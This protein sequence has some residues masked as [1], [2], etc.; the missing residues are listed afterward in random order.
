MQESGIPKF[1]MT[2]SLANKC[3]TPQMNTQYCV[4]ECLRASKGKGK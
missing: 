3:L 4:T 1:N 2:L